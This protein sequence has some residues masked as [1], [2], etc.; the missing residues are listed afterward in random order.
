[1]SM[2]DTQTHQKRVRILLRVSSNQQLDAD[3]DLSTQ[4]Q[5]ILEHIAKHDDWLLDSKE[6]FEGGIS[7]YRNAVSERDV[8]LEA[9]RDAR[10]LHSECR[11]L[12]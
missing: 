2:P 1:M 7:G 3:G 5:I 6:Y 11:V 10:I 8:L 12:E 9:L 4:R